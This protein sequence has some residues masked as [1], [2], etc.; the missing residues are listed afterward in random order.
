[1]SETTLLVD[2]VVS[3]L[4]S[5]YDGET[6]IVQLDPSLPPMLLLGQDP[7]ITA[8]E[9]AAMPLFNA[10]L[11]GAALR[12]GSLPNSIGAYIGASLVDTLASA[13]S[14]VYDVG[15][16]EGSIPTVFGVGCYWNS[17][18]TTRIPLPG[19]PV[20]QPIIAIIVYQQ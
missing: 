3:G 19:V 16:A 12:T 11:T 20:G 14:A 4:A 15:R 1:M 2:V 17:A 10:G 9:A 13:S 6:G 8:T 7:I 18:S 5:Y